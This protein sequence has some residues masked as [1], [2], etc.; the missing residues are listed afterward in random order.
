MGETEKTEEFKFAYL[1]MEINKVY[2]SKCY[3]QMM[4]LGVHPG[5]IPFLMLLSKH[6]EMSQREVARELHVK[7]PTVNV[8]VQRMEKAGFV[9][10]RQDE[11]DQRIS[12]IRLTEKGL[13]MKGKVIAHVEENDKY[14]L[15]NFSETEKCL[16][17]RFLRQ[18]MNNIK[19]IP[20]HPDIKSTEKGNLTSD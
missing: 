1:F 5:Q 13:E 7:P 19:S 17:G 16:L 18:I 14:I 20:E 6:G 2:A 4:K 15:Q 8:M 3:Q 11:K 12:R 10:R 9:I